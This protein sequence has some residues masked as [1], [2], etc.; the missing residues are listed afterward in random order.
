MFWK[1]VGE[2]DQLWWSG[3]HGEGVLLG[4]EVLEGDGISDK[5]MRKFAGEAGCGCNSLGLDTLA[6]LELEAA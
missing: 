1:V 2:L 5:D 4:V 6:H 3:L